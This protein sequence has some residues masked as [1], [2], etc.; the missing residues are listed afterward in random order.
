MLYSTQ[1]KLC[2]IQHTAKNGQLTAVDHKGAEPVV[3]ICNQRLH[4]LAQL[5]KQGLGICALDSVFNVIMLNKI[6]YALPV[7]FGY[8]TEGHKD[9]LSRVLK[10]SLIHI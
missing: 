9:M 2:A 7:Y 5:Q 4:L 6:L 3:A 8:L 1:Q 10:L